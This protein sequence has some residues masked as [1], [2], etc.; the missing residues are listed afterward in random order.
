MNKTSWA[1]QKIEE[2]D[3]VLLKLAYHSPGDL[4]TNADSDSV[5]L[6]GTWA[7]AFLTSSQWYLSRASWTTF[8]RSNEMELPTNF[9]T[10]SEASYLATPALCNSV[11]GIVTLNLPLQG[12]LVTL[13]MA[14]LTGKFYS[15]SITIKRFIPAGPMIPLMDINSK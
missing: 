4:I 12:K 11:A 1:S 8:L 3:V 9:F 15:G 2:R 7:S 14:M 10:F 13:T 5:G 6:G